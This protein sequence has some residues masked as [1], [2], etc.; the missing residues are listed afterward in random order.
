MVAYQGTDTRESAWRIVTYTWNGYVR[1][2]RLRGPAGPRP[3]LVRLHRPL[4]DR[5]DPA[6]RVPGRPLAARPA[7]RPRRDPRCVVMLYR[8]ARLRDRGRLLGADPRADPGRRPA[9]GRHGR[10]GAPVAPRLR[11]RT[12]GRLGRL[13]RD[14]GPAMGA[15]VDEAA[16]SA[17]AAGCSTSTCSCSCWRAS[18]RRRRDLLPRTLGWGPAVAG[19]LLA[20]ALHLA[21]PAVL[22]PRPRTPTDWSWQVAHLVAYAAHPRHR[23]ARAAAHRA[24]DPAV[25]AL[26][27]VARPRPGHRRPLAAARPASTRPQERISRRAAGSASVSGAQPV[28]PR[29]HGPAPS[30]RR[31][32]PALGPVVEVEGDPVGADRQPCASRPR[33]GRGSW[34]S[35]GRRGPP[36]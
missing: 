17:S 22:V 23:R 16:T 34:W 6:D 33:A 19:P 18:W 4:G 28:Q 27:E 36:R 31:P 10:G 20:G 12:P 15:V 25:A 24:A 21:L 11:R 26:G 1:E 8:A 9:V 35:G 3:P 30:R 32:Q 29:H 14:A 7:R 5:P 2:Q 13:R